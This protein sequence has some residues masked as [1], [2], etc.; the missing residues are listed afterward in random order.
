MFEPTLSVRRLQP[1]ALLLAACGI[2][3]L[4]LGTYFI[5][6]RPPLLPED[7][8]FLGGNQQALTA[9][10]SRLERW[11]ELV[12]T[13]MGGFMASTGVLTVYVAFTALARRSR[14][15]AIASAASTVLSLCL[16]SSVNFAL[17]SDFRWLLVVPPTIGLFA[18]ACYVR[19]R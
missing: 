14:S 18:I 12:F 1:S 2:W 7:V 17:G 3:L 5:F 9:I 6:V 10:T 11:L 4:A 8:R 19:G 13:V 16:M 15:A